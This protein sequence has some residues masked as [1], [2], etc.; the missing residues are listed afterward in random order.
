MAAWVAGSGYDAKHA[1]PTPGE[2]HRRFKGLPS[3]CEVVIQVVGSS[4]NPA[5]TYATS[6]VAGS[7]VSGIIVMA[8]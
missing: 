6:G 2:L 7:D 8:Y 3:P 1:T 5:D 4:V